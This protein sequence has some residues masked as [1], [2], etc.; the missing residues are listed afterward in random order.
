[1]DPQLF[2]QD[3]ER[4]P[5]T[6][7]SLATAIS[8]RNP[9]SDLL[10][11]GDQSGRKIV[12]LGMGSS[13]FANSVLALRLQAHG[14]W[15]IATLASTDP[16]PA[17][18]KNDLVIAVSAGGSSAETVSAINKFSGKCQTIAL[19]NTS[20]SLIEQACDSH[21]SMMAEI[22]EGGVAC[23]SFAHT[24]AL[25][26]A[27]L[28]VLTGSPRASEIISL[29]ADS[30]QELLD[31]REQ[32]LAP[33]TEILLG[34][35]G[36]TIVAPTR[37]LASAQQSALM[38]REGPRL[39]AIACETGDWSHIDVYLTK[40][41]DYRMLVL[42][43]SDWEEQMLDWCSQRGS[44]V[45]VAGSELPSTSMTLRYVNDSQDDVRLLTEALIMECIAAEKWI[46]QTAE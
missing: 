16:L 7:R 14:I 23:R 10:S 20:G 27:L 18:D 45:A 44:T 46:D 33:L 40:T 29:A 32:W 2:K 25:H 13:H 39:P 22:E 9:W 42:P 19:T 17:V 21:V 28:E 4:T 34:P 26:L 5:E 11:A 1:M 35:D 36:T 30:T 3:I 8:E 15:A 43:G 6:L 12:L 41:T 38:L 37:R 31:R 24:L